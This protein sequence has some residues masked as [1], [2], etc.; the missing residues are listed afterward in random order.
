MKA[1]FITAILTAASLTCTASGLK[2]Y[3]LSVGEF[4]EL[5]V[6]DGINV[7]YEYDSYKAGKVEFESTADVASSIL[8]QPSSG[9]LKIELANR[10]TVYPSLPTV[11][12]YSTFLSKVSNEGDSTLRVLS[13]NPGP[14][15][16]ARVIGNGRLVV[17][18]VRTNNAEAS[19]LSGKGTL[20]IYGTTENASLSVTGAGQIQ[21]DDLKANDVK[22]TLTGTGSVFCYPVE[23]L[24]VKGVGS[25]KVYYRGTPKIK[26]NW[27][28]NAKII[29]LDN[30]S[31][32]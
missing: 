16:K 26:K 6:V 27:I 29:S 5:E 25:I 24:Y 8:F 19:I 20:V 13:I 4:H 21:A 3:E 10:D 11:K 1:R 7:D 23:S 28:S 15:L 17:R 30:D 32:Q 22:C 31:E 18:N 12:V 14:S 9:K 2:H